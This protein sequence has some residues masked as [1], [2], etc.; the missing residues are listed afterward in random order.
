[1]NTCT[2][3]KSGEGL[4][5][6]FHGGTDMDARVCCACAD[7]V[8]AVLGGQLVREG[9]ADEALSGWLSFQ[10]WHEAECGPVMS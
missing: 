1:M 2:R 9:K 8:M 3:C 5:D 4:H 10:A 6:V 7:E